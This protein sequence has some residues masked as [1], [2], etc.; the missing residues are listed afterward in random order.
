MDPRARGIVL[1]S[2]PVWFELTPYP[3]DPMLSDVRF[4][5]RKL[6]RSP[7]F[8]VVAVLTLA[9]GIGANSAIFS[10]VYGV[11]YRPL[12]F[13][14]PHELVRVYSVL[15]G[16]RTSVNTGP[17][18]IEISEQVGAFSGVLAVQTGTASVTGE[19]DPVEVPSA[20]VS[21]NFFEMLGVRPARGRGFA[22]EE[23]EP[24]GNDVVVISHDLWRSHFGGADDVVGSTLTVDGRTLQV[25]GVMPASFAYPEGVRVWLPIAYTEAFR[26]TARGQFQLGILARLA[27]GSSIERADAELE[28]W[29]ASVRDRFPPLAHYQATV[30]PLHEATVGDLRTPLLML[31]GAVTFVL[32]IACANIANLLLARA[33]ARESEFAVRRALGAGRRRILQ[34]L[35][36]ES[37]ILGLAGGV[38]GV[39]LA[40]WGTE[41]LLALRPDGLPRSGEIRVDRPV[42]FFAFG[43][44]VV[45]GLLFGLAPALQSTRRAL[46]V[47]L[48]ESG[49]SAI[50]GANAVRGALVVSE[51]ALAIVLLA[52]AGLLINS[53]A[54]VLRI[55]PGFN[56][57]AAATTRVWL[58]P[59]AYA[60][61]PEI[62]A[63]YDQIM[64]N[65]AALP[66]ARAAGA[67]TFLPLSDNSMQ[68]GIEFE[69]REPRPAGE[70]DITHVRG[71]TPG[72]FAAAEVN[73]IGGRAF[74][75]RDRAGAVPVAI[76]SEEFARRYYPGEDPIGQRFTLT[77]NRGGDPVGAEIVGIAANT[78]LSNIAEAPEPLLY[79]AQAQVP[80]RGMDVV[81]RAD[82]ATAPLADAVRREI[83]ALDP[84][85]P[86]RVRPLD[87]LVLEATSQAK[88]YMLLLSVFAGA[89]LLLAG[90]GIFGLFSYV[91]EQ[92]RRE[93][94]IRV[95]LGAGVGTVL[96]MILGQAGRLAALGILIGV[97][98][99]LFLAR[100]LNTLLYDVGATDPA[101]FV[102]ATAVLAVVALTASYLPARAAA[103]LDPNV[104]LRSD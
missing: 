51:V 11:L 13:E 83:H 52:G 27:P 71:A 88:F 26:E 39:L 31:L 35:L 22:P 1:S 49:R 78:K 20:S 85:L 68:L 36:V 62:T 94:G 48:K 65:L 14:R 80:F 41:A 55:D 73:I 44:S 81:V 9:I 98:A 101:T 102:A 50:G 17:N 95:A 45:A 90:V 79:L 10:V 91:V 75:E 37:V 93:I 54:R 59:T 21:A 42:L 69:G 28:A 86:V 57:D 99:A 6:I 18:F 7:L 5:V 15:R 34:Q 60:G 103:R 87:E 89:A 3:R 32:L 30:E 33:T 29:A 74:D 38:I 23:N 4:A 64:S 25:V 16:D 56:P 61:D 104:A 24:G 100:F 63:F 19:F 97:P 47:T 77:W 72:F 70:L 96:G 58:P 82:L 43:I 66:G 76:V 40:V 53:F 92:R 8:T 67:V 12:P 46:A 84:N 2:K